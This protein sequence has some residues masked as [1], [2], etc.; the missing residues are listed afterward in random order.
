MRMNGDQ[1]GRAGKLVVETHVQLRQ[2]FL[3]RY[4]RSFGLISYAPYQKKLTLF[5]RIFLS[6]EREIDQEK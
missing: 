4:A 1:K 2:P 6:G 5:C 3:A